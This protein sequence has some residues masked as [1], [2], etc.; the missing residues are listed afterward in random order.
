MRRQIDPL[1]LRELES[2]G[3]PY[4]IT[5]GG[6]HLHIR[7]AGHLAA[8]A[9]FSA[10]NS[11]NMRGTLNFRANIRRKIKELQACSQPTASR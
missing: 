9:P 7:I 11:S 4:T 1:I 2:C 10:M 3:L 8:T 5:N 6:K